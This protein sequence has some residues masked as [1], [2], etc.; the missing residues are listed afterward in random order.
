M[1]DTL[2]RSCSSVFRRWLVT[3]LIGTSV[4]MA[5]RVPVMA[6]GEA[7]PVIRFAQLALDCVHR[8]YPNKVS[9]V[10]VDDSDV[11][12]PRELTPAFYGCFDWHS[13]VHAHWLLVRL[14]RLYPEVDLAGLARS[15]LDS[16]LTADHIADEVDYL[17]APGREGFERPYGLAWLLQLAA[18]LREWDDPDAR[19]WQVALAPL[20]RAAALRIKDW[21]PKLLYPVRSGEHS[22]TAFSFSLV[23]DWAQ[24]AADTQ[25]LELLADRSADHYSGDKNCPLNYEPS[26]QDFLSP[27]LAEA[28]LMRRM[29]EP[30]LFGAWLTRLLPGI[31]GGAD[32]SG[33]LETATV[34]DPSDG[35]L[36]HLGGLNLSRA[37]MLEGIASG[38]PEHDQ[39]RS[40][41]LAAALDHRR[42]GLAV[43]TGG[44]Y[45]GEHWLGTFATYLVTERGLR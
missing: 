26:G 10:L 35:Q 6:Q 11:R 30:A 29:I 45:E 14:V 16:S 32:Q 36:M 8:E 4:A 34:S 22:Q 28:D 1:S 33:W 19:R 42:A 38:L 41:L 40:T 37:W 21:L 3:L 20:E 24:V 44:Y 13:S 15:K 27:C 2:E 17:Q 25:M 23:Y 5:F 31:S 12:P 43:V 39:R 7:V 9:H 18:E